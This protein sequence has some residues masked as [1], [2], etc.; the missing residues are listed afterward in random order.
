M[1]A[2]RARRGRVRRQPAARPRP[3]PHASIGA[4]EGALSLVTWPGYAEHGA[5]DPAYDWVTPVRG[6][7]P[8]ARSDHP[9]V[10][11][12]RRGVRVH[13]TPAI[14]R[15]LGVRRREPAASSW[16]LRRRRSTRI[17]SRTTPNISAGLKDKAV[18]HGRR[19][20]LRHP[21]RPGPEP[22]DVQ[23]RQVTPEPTSWVRCAVRPQRTGAR[24]AST[25]SPI[26]IADAA[27]R[28]DDDEARA[29][30]QEPV[31]A[32]R[33][34]VPRRDRPAQ[35]AAP[36]DQASTGRTTSTRWTSFRQRRRRPSAPAGSSQQS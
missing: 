7:R 26:Y 18:Q 15:H 36:H 8:A 22:P 17:C 5:T 14:R 2:R 9:D 27:L 30:D 32:R 29:R 25:T 12:V 31:P 4:G 24:S 21:A 23:H 11:H 16:R 3:T 19:R 6:R 10:R 20:P 13:A 33:Q 34:A 35:G 28:P 1:P